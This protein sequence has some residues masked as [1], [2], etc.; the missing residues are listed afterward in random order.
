VFPDRSR[1]REPPAADALARR[2]LGNDLAERRIETRAGFSPAMGRVSNPFTAAYGKTDIEA[3][4]PDAV[5][6][7]VEAAK[8]RPIK[9]IANTA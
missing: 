8:I 5:P 7:D 4:S 9:M 2:N 6:G 3:I 1:R